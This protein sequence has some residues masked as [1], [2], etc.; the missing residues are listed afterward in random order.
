MSIKSILKDV[1]SAFGDLCKVYPQRPKSLSE[2]L[3]EFIVVT[4]PTAV[5]NNELSSNGEYDLFTAGV[6]IEVYVRGRGGMLVGRLDEL[7]RSILERFPVVGD[8]C[9]TT[10]PT[11]RLTGSDGNGYDVANII[12]DVYTR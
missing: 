4:I 12:A 11:L 3:D 1:S 9:V 10:R 2:P 6:Q 5:E 8:S 7:T